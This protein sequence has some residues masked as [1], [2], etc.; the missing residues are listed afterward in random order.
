MSI[1]VIN[2]HTPIDIQRSLKE[3]GHNPVAIPICNEVAEPLRGHPDLQ[4]CFIKK[5]A[6]YQPLLDSAFL[7]KISPH[8]TLVKGAN[9]ITDI[10]PN[11]ISYNAAVT[12][13]AVFGL[14]ERTDPSIIRI[15]D[16]LSIPLINIKQGYGKC[17]TAIVD[18]TSIITSDR[19]I[20]NAALSVELNSLLIV[21]GH[22]SLPGYDFGFIG[23]AS[24]HDKENF[25]VCGTLKKHPDYNKIVKFVLH[26]EK[27]YIELGTNQAIDL[28]SIFII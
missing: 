23:G 6:V 8:V 19:G 22:I 20:H 27:N 14:K 12:E 15:L 24:G 13:R 9:P 28:G 7:N 3:L 26:C 1:A 11:D 25:Y 4:I 17:S 2:P 18:S 10:Y 16:T 21:P 5:Y